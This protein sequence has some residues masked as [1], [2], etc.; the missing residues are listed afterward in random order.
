MAGFRRSDRCS[1]SACM[2]YPG[3]CYRMQFSLGTVF[4]F[5]PAINNELYG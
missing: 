5:P 4:R 3:A 1:I 2:F